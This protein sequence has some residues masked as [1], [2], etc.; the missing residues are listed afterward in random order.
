LG[1]GEE[2]PYEVTKAQAK[3]GLGNEHLE[4]LQEGLLE[5]AHAHVKAI[6][7]DLPK[8]ID[9]FAPELSVEV[10]VKA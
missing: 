3:Y 1:Y 6:W 10:P 2:L 5:L 8:Q 7:D 9:R 4:E